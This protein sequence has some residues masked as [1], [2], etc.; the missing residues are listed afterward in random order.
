LGR[1]LVRFP[2]GKSILQLLAAG[3]LVVAAPLIIAVMVAV[4][5]V[6]RLARQ[7]QRAV[8]TAETATQQS[9]SISEH[10]TAMERSLGQFAVLGDDELFR[11]YLARRADFGLAAGNLQRFELGPPLRQRLADLLEAEASLHAR[12]M[13]EPTR[14]ND[15]G[16]LTAA[17]TGLAEQA[18]VVAAESRALVEM[19]AD[20]TRNAA[21][22]L[23]RLLIVLAATAIPAALGLALLS[24]MLINR[25]LT[26]I[27]AAIS[28]LGAGDFASAVKI[29]GPQD[30]RELGDRLDWLRCRIA[31]L[32]NEKVNFLRQ[33]SHELKTPLSSIREG[34]ELLQDAVGGAPRTD[35]TR[36]IAR[37]IRESSLRLQELIED[38]LQ[39]GKA[40]SAAEQEVGRAMCVR[41][42]DVID[43]VVGKHKLTLRAKQLH[44]NL[45]VPDIAVQGDPLQLTTVLDNIISNA[46]RHSPHTGAIRVSARREAGQA[47]VEV[48]DQGPGVADDERQRVFEPFY[49][50]RAAGSARLSGTGLGLAIVKRF[51]EANG[52]TVEFLESTSGARVR[53]SLPVAGHG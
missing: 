44:V 26:A 31:A 10:L 48:E 23:Q 32:E 51:V 27:K 8:L 40:P 24:I 5:Q 4:L 30:L 35:E 33:V 38:L 47:I 46:I 29:R 7:S 42:T 9:R 36:E 41:L 39:F 25:P 53:A 15:V 28:R 21:A 3:F 14:F 22:R 49:Q 37:I 20:R 52:G 6:E 18:R 45:E 43:Q 34:A 16:E 2:R 17:F 19:E 50:G 11:N 1:A 12:I 13:R